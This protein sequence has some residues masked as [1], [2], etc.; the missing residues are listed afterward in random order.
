MGIAQANITDSGINIIPC[1]VSSVKNLNDF[2]PTIMAAKEG[3]AMLKAIA[4][5]ST[6]FSLTN[7]LWMKD[8]YVVAAGL[9]NNGEDEKGQAPATAD[10]EAQAEE[11]PEAGD[12]APEAGTE[13]EAGKDM[14]TL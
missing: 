13:P 7:A 6:N 1:T 12:E 10:I 2:Q 9:A 14:D 11:A 8:N 3:G 5:R 4:S